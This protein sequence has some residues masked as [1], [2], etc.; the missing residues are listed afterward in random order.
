MTA[1]SNDNARYYFELALSKDPDNAAARQGLGMVASKLVLQARAEIDTGQLEA[2]DIL[3]ADARRL[4]PASSELIASISA[5]DTARARLRQDELDAAERGAAE[6]A[7]A[8]QAEAERLAAEQLA[9]E[10]QAS[11]PQE[12]AD[13]SSPET[14]NPPVRLAA[15]SVSSLT[16]TKYVAPKYPRAAQRR[17]ING[18]VDVAF[19]VD[20]DGSVKD[21]EVRDSNPGVT[22]VNAAVN[23]VE[24]WEFEPIVENDKAIQKRAAVRMMFAIE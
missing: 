15:V 18:W 3:L 10:N 5:L 23:A 6:T 8:E 13:E 14:V 16:R 12:I 2:A 4:D 9:F 17:S 22:F 21:I 1:P 19:T 7:A 11:A 20:F 24:D